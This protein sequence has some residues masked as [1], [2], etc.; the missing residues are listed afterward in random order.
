MPGGSDDQLPR[1]RG[2]GRPA[3]SA[4]K[5]RKHAVT[6][7]LTDD[8]S[9]RVDAARGGMT[10]GEYIRRAALKA[11]PRV[12][13]EINREAWLDLARATGNLNQLIAN[14]NRGGSGPSDAKRVVTDVRDSVARLRLML[15]GV[16]PDAI[17]PDEEAD[18]ESEN[19]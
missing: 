10:R 13:P 5:Q 11:P 6:C 8:E 18:D 17:R 3:V 12:V 16:D 4:E 7:R 15:I 9:E 2:R 19:R 1:R 14:M